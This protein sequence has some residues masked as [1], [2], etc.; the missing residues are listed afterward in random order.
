MIRLLTLMVLMMG[1]LPAKA[2]DGPMTGAA[3]M[4]Y[5][6]GLYD[7]D[8]GFCAG[9]ITAIADLM[10]EQGLYGQTTCNL[11]PVPSQQLMELVQ[12]QMQ[13][14]PEAQSQ[15]ATQ[16]TATTLARFYPCR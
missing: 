14:N 1:A 4:Q 9:Y 12:I 7:V 11:G 16:M 10:K 3:L 13:D 6:K 15:S 8:A 2:A 5:C